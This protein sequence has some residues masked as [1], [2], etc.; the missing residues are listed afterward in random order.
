MTL[1]KM[2]KLPRHSIFS[3]GIIILEE[4]GLIREVAWC[5]VVGC[6]PDSDWAI[7]HTGTS[8]IR[9]PEGVPDLND[10]AWDYGKKLRNW[11]F[12]R[13]LVPCTKEVLS[14]YRI[15]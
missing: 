10:V 5:A 15:L 9:Q 11:H 14:R 6:N 4:E 13:K 12:I 3:R 2:N 7:Y 8:N 1:E